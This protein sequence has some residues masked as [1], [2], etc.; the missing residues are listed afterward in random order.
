[1]SP[2]YSAAID[3]RYWSFGTLFYV[4]GIGLVEAD[5]TGSKVLGRNRMDICVGDYAFA[6]SLGRWYADVWLVRQ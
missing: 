3:R 2:G 5:D 1:M 6:R 4:S